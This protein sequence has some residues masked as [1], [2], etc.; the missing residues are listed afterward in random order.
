MGVAGSRIVVEVGNES[1]DVDESVRNGSAIRH[2][3]VL[4]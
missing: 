1:A 4:S 3:K 2:N